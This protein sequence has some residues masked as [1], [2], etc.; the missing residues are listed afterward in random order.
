MLKKTITF[1]DLDGNPV[2]ED[3]YFNLSKP[4]LAELELSMTGGFSE[5]LQTL[6]KSE[7]GGEIIKTFKEIL[8]VSIG[9]RSEDNK[10]FV[11]TP[12][13]ADEF[14]ESDAYSVLFMQLISD[15]DMATSFIEGVL[16]KNLPAAPQD[17][18]TTVPS[19]IQLPP[20]EEPLVGGMTREQIEMA[21]LAMKKD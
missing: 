6:I 11:K 5:Y 10:R 3:F 20:T 1:E 14:F 9:R 8:R 21:F 13:I 4:E 18:L 17:S 15:A 19:P 7:N 16:P 12:Q 2:T